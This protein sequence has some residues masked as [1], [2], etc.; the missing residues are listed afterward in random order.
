MLIEY[1]VESVRLLI[2]EYSRESL[3]N[4]IPL[5]YGP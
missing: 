2:G 5:K 4:F 1:Y 3:I